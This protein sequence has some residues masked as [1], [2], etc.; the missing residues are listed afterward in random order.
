MRV[1]L[2]STYELGHQP[3]HLAVPAGELRAHG[4]DVRC[5]DLSVDRWDPAVLDGVDRVA[6]SAPMH[7]ATRLAQP[8]VADIDV[9]VATYGLYGETF[10]GEYLAALLDWVEPGATVTGAP[11]ARDLLP[12]LDRYARLAVGDDLKL[13]GAVEAGRGC[14][15][16]CRHCPVPAVY[17]GRTKIVAVDEV[18]ADVAQLVELGAEHITFADPDFLSG[19]HHARRVV[20]AVHGAFPSLTFDITT[21]VEL[22]LRHADLFDGFAA[23][24]C[25]FAISAVECVDDDVLAILDKGHTAADAARA[26][27]LLRASGIEPRPSLMPFTPW[28]TRESLVELATFAADLDLVGS[29]DPVHWSIRLLLPAG[30]LLLAEP[31]LEPF[32]TGFDPELLGHQWRSA[33]PAMDELQRELAVIV[34]AG[35]GYDEVCDVI[36]APRRAGWTPATERPHLTETW[37][38]CAEPTAAQLSSVANELL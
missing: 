9:P 36:G 33:D 37:F 3:V 19:P 25:L 2:I 5:V 7:T 4:H 27:R 6:I 11:P 8:L 21:K 18:V 30:S 10:R 15:S 16:R 23:A 14:I 29:I 26:V 17:D 12:P 24:G 22:V 28:T 20:D 38:C 34:E 13:A 32:L 31:R 1:L 35:G